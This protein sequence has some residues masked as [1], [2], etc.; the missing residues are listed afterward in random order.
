MLAD[1]EQHTGGDN[2]AA[3]ETAVRINPRLETVHQHLAEHYRKQGDEEKVALARGA[4]EAHRRAAHEVS[5]TSQTTHFVRGSTSPQNKAPHT[6]SHR[7][8]SLPRPV[9]SAIGGCRVAF[10]VDDNL[11]V[12]DA[13]ACVHLPDIPGEEVRHDFGGQAR[14]RRAIDEM[15]QRFRRVAC[16]FQ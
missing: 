10:G 7:S 5:G 6:P 13:A 16:L 14:R 4:C 1:C 8:S 12:L 11:L 2:T 9:S 3:L 15:F